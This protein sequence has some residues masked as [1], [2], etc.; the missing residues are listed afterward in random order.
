MNGYENEWV[1]RALAA[2]IMGV[3]Q[4]TIGRY[5]AD[6][7]LRYQRDDRTGRVRVKLPKAVRVQTDENG[8]TPL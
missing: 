8:V 7:K 4:R 5:M 1:T 6:G 3:S 2:E